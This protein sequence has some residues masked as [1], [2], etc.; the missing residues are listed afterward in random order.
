[1]IKNI[2]QRVFQVWGPMLILLV[3][4]KLFS[5]ASRISLRQLMLDPTEFTDVPFYTGIMANLGI[6]LW[7]ATASICLFVAIF[8]PQLVGKA[9]KDFFLVFGLLTL[10]L[11]IDDLLRIHDEIF[12]VYFGIKGDVIGIGYFLLTLLCLLRYRSLIFQYPYTFLVMA[13]GLFAVSVAIDVAPPVIKHRFSA[14]DL[15]FFE[16][17]AKLLGIA[18]WLAYFAHLSA[19]ILGKADLALSKSPVSNQTPETTS[20][21]MGKTA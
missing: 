21:W 12:P 15:L 16:D 9:W 5:S 19:A 17:S 6:L 11:L 4:I 1:M 2:S 10:L 18:N 20:S 13:L 14:A 8:L 7:A 3:I